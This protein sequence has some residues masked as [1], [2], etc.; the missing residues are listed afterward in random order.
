MHYMCST[1]LVPFEM[2]LKVNKSGWRDLGTP[3]KDGYQISTMQCIAVASPD[4]K[5]YVRRE[6]REALRLVRVLYSPLLVHFQ[7]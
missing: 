3:G 1:Y 7:M 2:G 4:A 5:P 6:A